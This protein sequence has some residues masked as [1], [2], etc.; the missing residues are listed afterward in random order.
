MCYVTSAEESSE[1]QTCLSGEETFLPALTIKLYASLNTWKD[2]IIHPK[3]DIK[4]PCL[5]MYQC[6]QQYV[7]CLKS[8]L[9]N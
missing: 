1:L 7:L 5:I 3:Q 8:H 6:L 4:K 2:G 9:R